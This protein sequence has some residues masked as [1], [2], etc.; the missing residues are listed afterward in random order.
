MKHLIKTERLVIRLAEPEDAE[1]IFSYRFDL[2]ENKYQGWFPDSVE[3]VHDYISDMPETM[4]IANI[5]FQFAIILAEENRLI[6]DMGIIFTNH[7]NMQ[8]EI[9]C[10]L[11]KDYK[12]LGYATEALNGMIGFLF[13]TLDKHRIIASVDPRNTASIRLIER[14]GFRKEAHFKESYYLRGEWVDDIIYAKLKTEWEKSSMITI[15]PKSIALQFNECITNADLNGLSNLMTEDYIFIDTANNRIKGK[16]NNIVHAW[17]P[18]F[19]LY[20]GYQ[21]IFE[22]IVVR[23]STVIM[24]GYSICSDEILNNIHAIWIAKIIKNKVGSWHIYSDTKANRELF[25]L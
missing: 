4:D 11:H 12:G 3:E 2:V 1:S 14:L 6:G 7:D 19:N 5:C 23:G 21:N 10:T 8:A 22:N 18:F 20:P 17:Q 25:D 9:G 15:D 13:G 24:Q 16:N